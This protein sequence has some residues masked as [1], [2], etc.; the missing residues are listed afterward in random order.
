MWES[1]Y[2]DLS[3]LSS[4]AYLRQFIALRSY[5]NP[6]VSQ[7]HRYSD[8]IDTIGAFLARSGQHAVVAH[9]MG[10]MVVRG[11]YINNSGGARPKISG[12]VTVAAPHRGTKLADH[13]Y[14]AVGF[15]ADVQ[16]RVNGALDSAFV[17]SAVLW[18][19]SYFVPGGPSIF[20]RFIAVLLMMPAGNQVALNDITSIAKVPALADLRTDSYA[21]NSLGS[22]FH[23]GSIPRANIYGSIPFKHAAI[24]VQKSI[25]DRDFEFDADVRTRNQAVSLF[26]T[27][28]YVG[29]A[30]IILGRQGRNCSYAVKVLSRVDDRWVKYVNGLDANG[31]LR[32]VPFDGVVANERSQ[33]PST[34]SINYNVQ[35]PGLNHIN[36][37]KTRRGL[38]EIAT[39]MIRIGMEQIQTPP[40]GGGGD[41]GPPP[42][43][44]PCPPP[45]LQC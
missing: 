8:H 42:G 3:N 12:I 40:S 39:G 4:P 27:C 20:I 16:R 25:E 45:Q 43:D 10:S 37:Y 14:E 30:T 7:A 32:R 36:I 41:E 5:D 34:N 38:D 28:K 21:V 26:K 31:N 18:L 11:V 33:Y 2:Q 19:L 22:N 44:E 23:D 15:F 1:G 29:Y 35:I 6:N 9:S 17:Q 13:A 24:R